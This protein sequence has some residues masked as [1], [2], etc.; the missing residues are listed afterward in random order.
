MKTSTNHLQLRCD[1]TDAKGAQCANESLYTARDTM[2]T[3]QAALN[4]G[5]RGLPLTSDEPLQGQRALELARRDA[6]PACAS[7]AKS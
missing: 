3:A 7:R 1:I 4:A 2:A 6:C 5:W